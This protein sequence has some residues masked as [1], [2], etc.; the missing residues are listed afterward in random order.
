MAWIVGSDKLMAKLFPLW[1]QK[2][3]LR[4]EMAGQV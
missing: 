3:M 1:V 2:S 4:V